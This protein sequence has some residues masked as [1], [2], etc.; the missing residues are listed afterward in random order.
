MVEERL[1]NFS[2]IALADTAL[3]DEVNDETL[4]EKHTGRLLGKLRTLAGDGLFTA[5]NH[6][7]NWQKAHNILVPAFARTAMTR[8]HDT[9]TATVRELVDAWNAAST[10]QSWIDIPTE[11][12][13]LTIE[14]IGR[15]GLGHKFTKLTEPNDNPFIEAVQRQLR[16]A[17]RRT[18]S[19]PFYDNV[20]G[21]KRKRQHEA[22]KAY[23]R[24]W[25]TEVI[26]SR[27]HNQTP[28]T[29]NDILDIMQHSAD[30]DTGEHLDTDNIIN[31]II[32][33]LVAGSETS[34]NTIAFALHYLST[35][36]GIAAAARAEIDQRWP[37]RDFPDISFEDVAKLRYLLRVV[38]EALRLWPVAPAYFRQAKKDTAL[39]N[40]KYPFRKGEW[41]VVML[42]A[43]HRANVWGHDAD[44]F[45]P[46]RFLPENL[47]K[48]PP[49]I[50]KP[51]G[52]GARAC[53]G[54]QFA[55]HEML[56]TLAVILHQYDLQPKPGYQLQV[57]DAIAQR[58]EGLQL[59]LH[60]RLLTGS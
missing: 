34:A 40:G 26:E 13:R 6:E 15:A 22:D 36:T 43:A 30:P 37:G 33:L 8:Y 49:H 59:R 54:R 24:R 23:I 4:W 51:F 5:Y 16:Y 20:F 56:V 45:I 25:V 14:I 55:L 19:I 9:M 29:H 52:T 60:R 35:N 18:D 44:E 3:I 41:V 12:N 31:Q 57:R 48:L 17:N 1:F 7:P 46:D 2:I 39:G 27:R 58:P 38:D 11:T 42:T 28:A 10:D 21:Y 32:T 50:Y 53:I 47:R